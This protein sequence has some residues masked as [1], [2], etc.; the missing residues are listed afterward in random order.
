ML[1]HRW[2]HKFDLIWNSLHHHHHHHHHFGTHN[3]SELNWRGKILC[4]HWQGRG[5]HLPQSLK[6]LQ[7]HSRTTT[8]F[9]HSEKSVLCWDIDQWGRSGQTKFLSNAMTPLKPKTSHTTE[10]APPHPIDHQ[11]S[12]SIKTSL[13]ASRNLSRCLWWNCLSQ[14]TPQLPRRILHCRHSR[15]EHSQKVQ[16]TPSA[17]HFSEDFDVNRTND[18]FYKV[19]LDL[20]CHRSSSW[21]QEEYPFHGWLT[22]PLRRRQHWIQSVGI[23]AMIIIWL[24]FMCSRSRE[25]KDCKW[26]R[27]SPL[28]SILQ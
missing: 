15:K 12:K 20:R 8:S 22:G 2:K 6:C 21:Q 10:S 4:L 5:R 18:R 9:A 3:S 28:F 17:C 13:L 27:P 7:T 24:I 11:L 1:V 19:L 16:F 14:R 26:L 23:V 25:H